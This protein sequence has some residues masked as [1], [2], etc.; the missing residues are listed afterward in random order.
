MDL[1]ISH[2]VKKKGAAFEH[3]VTSTVKCQL[4]CINISSWKALKEQP[5]S[6]QT[7]SHIGI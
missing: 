4:N 3:I 6:L 2:N 7:I 1:G 5:H